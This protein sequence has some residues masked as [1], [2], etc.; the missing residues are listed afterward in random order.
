VGN[1]DGRRILFIGDSLSVAN[2]GPRLEG[3]LAAQGAEVLRDAKGGRSVRWFYANDGKLDAGR[4]PGLVRDI[5]PT[6]VV[7]ALGTNDAGFGPADGLKWWSRFMGDIRKD[8]TGPVKFYWVTPPA[9][10]ARAGKVKTNVEAIREPLATLFDGVVDSQPLTLDLM[11]PSQ[12][13][14]S[15][16]IH[17]AKKAAGELW[18]D[19]V[20]EELLTVLRES[21]QPPKSGMNETPVRVQT[22]GASG[23][24]LVGG[25]IAF[26]ILLAR[27][28]RR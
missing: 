8:S 24:A 22:A 14:S 7:L 9:F 6:D 10:D 13:R 21:T 28:T 5:D 18:A 3:N 17:F 4:L 12:G 16:Y 20:T 11:L 15:D 27:L 2:F 1:L 26:A 25:A 19:R 23:A